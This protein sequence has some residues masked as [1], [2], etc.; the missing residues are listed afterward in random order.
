LWRIIDG[1]TDYYI[2][3]ILNL[4]QSVSYSGT[5]LTQSLSLRLGSTFGKWKLD[6]GINQEYNNIN[7]DYVHFVENMDSLSNIR[8]NFY[9]ILPSATIVYNVDSLQDIKLSYSRTVNTPYFSQLD[10]FVNKRN[11]YSWSSGNSDLEAVSYNNIYLGYSYNQSMWNVSAELFY[12]L[13]NNEIDYFSFPISEILSMT[14]PDNI[15]YQDRLG[16]DLSAYMSINGKYNFS[17]SSSIYHSTLDASNLSESFENIGVSVNEVVKKNYGFNA[18]LSTDVS[19]A[20]NTSAMIYVNYYS[21]EVSFD[22]YQFA[23]LN[24]SLGLTQRFFNR[25]LTVSVGI[26]NLF[27]DMMDHGS[28]TNNLGYESTTDNYY[29]TSFCRMYYISLNYRFRQGDRNTSSVGQK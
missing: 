8:K 18:K 27:D 21:R 12:S 15:A 25:S 7:I 28:Y 6:A 22:G 11:P 13:T 10:A 1:S 16:V 17:L 26:N 5:N 14:L 9:N 23:K 29:S 3:D 2:D 19:L 24:S 4:P 20:K